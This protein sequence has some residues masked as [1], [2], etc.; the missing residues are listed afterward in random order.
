[1]IQQKVNKFILL[2]IFFSFCFSLIVSKHYLSK[3]DKLSKHEGHIYHQMI[4]ADPLRY[5]GHGDEISQ[6]IKEGKNFFKT[7][8]EN[9]TKYLPPRIAS[10]YFLIFNESL[11]DK[12]TGLI[13]TGIYFPYLFLQCLFFYSSILYFYFVIKDKFS[14]KINF[15]IL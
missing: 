5:M 13:K 14:S 8:R 9:Y 4:K 3:Y 1:M 12:K 2:L 7:G 11:Y 6:N 15:F 10:L